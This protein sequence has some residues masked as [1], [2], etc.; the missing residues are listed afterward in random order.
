MPHSKDCFMP[1]QPD[2]FILTHI[3][4]GWQSTITCASFH[5]AC[6]DSHPPHIPPCSSLQL[7]RRGTTHQALCKK[8]EANNSP[9]L[10][11]GWQESSYCWEHLS[12]P[13]PATWSL[14]CSVITFLSEKGLLLGYNSRR[15][16]RTAKPSS[17]PADLL[18]QLSAKC[19]IFCDSPCNPLSWFIPAGS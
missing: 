8:S 9:F 5:A 11:S 6:Q 15:D 2:P 16:V 10:F 3:L 17:V 18:M 14:N 19:A 12:T 4:L 1:G 7:A 13:F